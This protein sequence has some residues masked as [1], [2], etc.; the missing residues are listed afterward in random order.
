MSSGCEMR[1]GQDRPDALEC[2]AVGTGE[3]A[4]CSLPDAAAWTILEVL[5][6]H[7]EREDDKT[8]SQN[9]YRIV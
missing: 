5:D 9:G 1:V 2:V 4:R 8:Y 6:I 3:S 7:P